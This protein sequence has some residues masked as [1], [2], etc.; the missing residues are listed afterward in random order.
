MVNRRN[1]VR[2]VG[3]GV[4]LTAGAAAVGVHSL[5]NDIPA[6]AI[7]IWNGPGEETD[8]R[9]R[10]VAYAVTA[11]NPHNRQPWLVDLREP[12]AIT[13]YCD[14]DRL[15]P[16]TDPFGRQILIGHGAF[17]ELMVMA[18]AQQGMRSEVTLWPEGEMAPQLR[19]WDTRP[20][21][22]LR[23]LPGA[24]A[25]PLFASVLQR[26]TPKLPF[27]TTR[28]MAAATLTALLSQPHGSDV[29]R[30]GG[31]ID[32]ARVAQLRA[33][34]WEAAKVELTT[35]R[36]VMESIR[37]MRIGPD[38]ILAHRDGLTI[39][40]RMARIASGLGQFDR[41]APPSPDSPAHKQA[42]QTFDGYCSTAMGFT[43]LST[44]G[45]SRSDQIA[46]GRAYVRQQL[47]ATQLGI[48]M[49]P[50]SQALQEFPE[51]APHYERAHRLLLD[52]AAPASARDATVQM[53]CR[54]GYASAAAQAT[55]RRTLS[56]FF[57]A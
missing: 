47:R 41:S 49:H 13:L 55:P 46:A 36:T 16:E 44:G 28:P 40:T 50:M 5:T 43:W 26:H 20:V 2:L 22:R 8:V 23:L 38:E 24:Q 30:A 10:A 39:N 14:N 18:L 31:T 45:N 48:G 53:L 15:L 1:F 37:L 33:L 56:Q 7:E 34:C 9:K 52:A 17:L 11:P 54:I 3:G 32:A 57:R 19:D 25:D 4:V 51:M 27:D 12:D 35:P 21:A 42:M 29:V 6:A